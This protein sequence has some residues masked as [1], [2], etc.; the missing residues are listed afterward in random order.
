MKEDSFVRGNIHLCGSG[1]S[2]LRFEFLLRLS[3]GINY[4]IYAIFNAQNIN[5]FVPRGT[6]KSPVRRKA[7]RRYILE[8]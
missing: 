4:N 2:W 6:I 3:A 5:R 7:E 8:S 1:I